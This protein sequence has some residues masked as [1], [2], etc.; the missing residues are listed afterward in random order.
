MV[1]FLSGHNTHFHAFKNVSFYVT[2][3]RVD[4]YI[5]LPLHAMTFIYKKPN[6]DSFSF[7]IT[8][9]IQPSWVNFQFLESLTKVN[10]LT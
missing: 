9:N 3:W 7:F 2:I 5:Y 4:I 6:E 1:W 10:N 8:E